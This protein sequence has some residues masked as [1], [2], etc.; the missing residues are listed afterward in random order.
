MASIGRVLG[1]AEVQEEL[2]NAINFVE[3]QKD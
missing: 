1:Y 2:K 3:T